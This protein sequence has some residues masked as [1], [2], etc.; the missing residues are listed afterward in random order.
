[1]EVKVVKLVSGEEVIGKLEE[2]GDDFIVLGN[3]RSLMMQ[4]GPDG[5]VGLGM[6]PFMPS[7]DNPKTDSESDVKIYSQFIMAE[8]TAV[9]S[10]LEEAYLRS[11]SKIALS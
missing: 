9:P 5:Q 10:A 11:T 4:Q 1:M 3:A 8:P 2:Q 7:A 6:V